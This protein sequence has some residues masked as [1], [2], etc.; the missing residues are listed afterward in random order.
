MRVQTCL[1][2]AYYR[3]QTAGRWRVFVIFPSDNVLVKQ[4]PEP[5]EFD[6]SSGVGSRTQQRTNQPIVGAAAAL[7]VSIPH[8]IGLGLLAFA[9]LAYLGS[10][11]ALAL[12]SAALPGALLTLLARSKGVVYGP[13]TAV[14]LLFG[15]MLALVV[16]AGAA[17][18]ISA[19]QAL[20]ITGV[21]AALGFLLQSLIAWSGLARLARFIPVAVTQGFAAGV[22]L[23]LIVAQIKGLHYI[24]GG[25][26][27][28][29]LGWHAAIALAVVAL[30]LVLQCLWPRFPTLLLAVIL[31][32]LPWLFW[33]PGVELSMAADEAV[34][35]LPIVPDWWAAPWGLVLDQVGF[36]LASLALLMAVVNSLEVLVYHQQ[37]ESEHGQHSP[38][39][40]VLGREGW[41]GAG[42]ALLGL[43]P[44]STSL[45]RSRTALFYTG[46]PSRRA[47]QWHALGL[48]AVAVSGY[49]WLPWVPMAVLMGALLIAGVRMIPP[50]LWKRPA[51]REERSSRAQAWVVALVF[52]GTSGALAL[53]AGLLVATLELLRASGAHAIRR[54]HLEGKLRSRH[55]RGPQD[56]SWLAARMS[57]VAV[58]ELQGIFSFGVAAQV[59]EQVRAHLNGH[60]CVVLDASRVPSWDETGCLRLINLAHE[61]HAQNVALLLCGVHGLAAQRMAGLHTQPDLDRALEWAE[62][63]ILATRPAEVQAQPEQAT[64]VSALG[65]LGAELT[66]S[67]GAALQARMRSLRFAPGELIIRQGDLDRTL[68]WVKAGTVTLS[69]SEAPDQGVRLSVIGA[70]A[71][72]GEMAFLNGMARTAFAHAGSDGA[73]LNTLSWE[74][75]Q[76]WRQS[77]PEGALLFVTALAR[78]GIRRLGATSRELRAAME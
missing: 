66:A 51:A 16:G 26:W 41:V 30:S 3:P 68:L 29:L 55:V 25:Q 18:S 54:V 47:G 60:R 40:L 15:G 9:P 52:V 38:P 69:T 42:C 76:A 43:I 31:V 56:E 39:G 7:S 24:S 58:F 36:Q 35:L 32:A 74:Q 46:T 50:S 27:G 4:V 19:A 6:L 28:A 12:W 23:S 65:E 57:T 59:V 45:S 33:A 73:A 62:E 14:A 1:W 21:F 11:S 61:L 64:Q 71:V 37:L 10:A 48:I 17:V 70:G 2:V 22:G 5:I 53:L 78:M 72:F 75:F 44:A 67:Q 34:F 77:D 20:A 13:S 63:Q 49:L 8:A